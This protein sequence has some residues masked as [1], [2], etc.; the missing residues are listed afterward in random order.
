[1]FL[2]TAGALATEKYKQ[3]SFADNP[4]TE[5]PT[6]KNEKGLWTFDG[7]FQML[8]DH[9]YSKNWMGASYPHIGMATMNRLTLKYA[10]N[11]LAWETN[12]AVD[13][14]FKCSFLP[15][16]DPV[17]GKKIRFEK[18]VDV[19]DFNSKLGY[20]AKGYW[21][22]SLFY[23]WNTQILN[24]YLH[25]T[26]LTSAFMTK[27][28]MNL[29]FGMDYKR[30][31]WSWFISPIT[32]AFTFKTHPFL[33]DSLAYGVEAGKWCYPTMGA[34]TN[35]VFNADI[36]PKINLF[37]KLEFKMDYRGEFN[38]LRNID[39]SFEMK[40]LFSI[41]KWLSVSLNAALLYDYDTKFDVL[42][43]V[44]SPTGFKTDHL[45]FRESIGISLGYK[46]KIHQTQQF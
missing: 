43:A 1:L 24:G 9:S 11:K 6:E 20:R 45:Q 16:Q 26:T 44:G 31:M 12:L 42:D 5:Q 18:T 13:L 37:A 2:L 46:F 28:T 39:A 35:I 4:P 22:Y 25:D 34:M 15:Q 7:Q 30:K 3:H 40:W 27:G 29:S 17:T 21:F 36:H 8:L 32:A 14:G 23:N 10:K 33:R 41:T 38:Q 19:I